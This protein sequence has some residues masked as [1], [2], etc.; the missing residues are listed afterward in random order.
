VIQSSQDALWR[1][2]EP[3]KFGA[4][5]RVDVV[6]KLWLVGKKRL[7]RQLVEANQSSRGER[8]PG[9]KQRNTRHVI[10]QRF[11]VNVFVSISWR[12]GDRDI[13]VPAAQTFPLPT[14]L[15]FADG[16]LDAGVS[17]RKMIQK[18]AGKASPDAP[19]R[20]IY[21]AG[22]GLSGAGKP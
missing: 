22:A 13:D 5:F 7:I 8:M 12:R 15:T 20:D 10:Q 11:R 21:R 14:C 17:L 2:A 4:D 1:E 16:D 18:T 3:L 6:L 19:L 9:R